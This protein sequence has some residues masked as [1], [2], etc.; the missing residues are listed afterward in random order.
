MTSN[1]YAVVNIFTLYNCNRTRALPALYFLDVIKWYGY[2]S[3]QTARLINCNS[4]SNSN[5]DCLS[6]SAHRRL[7]L[8]RRVA[9]GTSAH[10]YKRTR[11]VSGTCSN[12][13]RQRFFCESEPK[14]FLGV[15][16]D[17]VAGGFVSISIYRRV[18]QVD[19][20]PAAPGTII[21]DKDAGLVSSTMYSI[22]WAPSCGCYSIRSRYL[23]KSQTAQIEWKKKKKFERDV[24]VLYS[25][26]K[27]IGWLRGYYSGCFSGL[28]VS[29]FSIVETVPVLF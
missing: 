23:S 25:N 8:V 9:V 24:N 21:V 16:D 22:Y 6:V 18:W 15:L 19:R 10:M 11:A 5:S 27:R 29:L 26:I 14:A 17:G 1:V 3:V 20:L 12:I 4:N 7:F 28:A 13:T 2:T